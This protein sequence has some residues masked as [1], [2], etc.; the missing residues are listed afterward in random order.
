MTDQRIDRRRIWSAQLGGTAAALSAVAFAPMFGRSATAALGD[1]AF[2]L[3][4]LV[5]VL[6]VTATALALG[7][8][9]RMVGV[10]RLGTG[11]AVLV[12]YV[13]LAVA[14]GPHV[15]GGPKRLL[16]TAFPIEPAGPE[17]AT[18]VAL[19]AL[20]GIFAAEAALRTPWPLAPLA[21]PL[22]VTIVG[23]VLSAGAGHQVWWLAPALALVAVALLVTG[24]RAHLAQGSELVSTPGRPRAMDAHHLL[25]APVMAGIAVAVGLAGLAG[26]DLVRLAGRDQPAD[27][28]ELVPQP[29]RP[30]QDVTPL[31]L[32]GALRTGRIRMDL[33]VTSEVP[34]RR[35]RYVTLDRFDGQ[36]WTSGA[37][38]IRAG[39]L[40]PEPRYD[41]PTE[42][43]EEHVEVV[44]PGPLGWLV[45]SGRPVRVSV[46][47]LGV[48]EATGDVV[49]PADR[50]VPDEFTVRSVVPR[51][52][53]EQL[54]AATP[55]AADNFG[56]PTLPPEIA[57]A[58]QA[59]QGHVGHRALYELERYFRS[60]PFVVDESNRPPT[61]HGLY[62][63]R[64]LLEDKTGTAEQ[65][66]SAFAVLAR[67]LGYHARV[68]VGFLPTRQ[69]DSMSTVSGRN[70]HAWVEVEF[71]RIG[72]VPYDPTPGRAGEPAADDAQGQPRPGE[73]QAPAD[74]PT[75][76]PGAH[77]DRPEPTDRTG[78]D[79]TE[80][81]LSWLGSAVAGLVLL[82]L[83]STAAV[84]V[85]KAF[86]RRR[87]SRL[88]DPDRKAAAAWRDTQERLAESGLRIRTSQTP[89]EVVAA[90]EAR[91]TPD[92][93]GALRGLALLHDEAAYAAD[94]IT[95][96]LAEAA[97]HQAGLARRWLA[98]R[99]SRIQRLR[100]A[101]D[102]RPLFGRTASNYQRETR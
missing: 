35:L 98:G 41:V 95:P 30:K 85:I 16:T 52:S 6:L 50:P 93:H 67:S 25:A 57:V 51:P 81:L 32:F 86:R 88:A 69:S 84:P 48:D 70:V 43:Y 54:A 79:R 71:T 76:A 18:V 12:V 37:R 3:S 7:V 23:V 40:L 47:D 14:P 91:F 68:V 100:A 90:A 65:Y 8:W 92:P 1:P 101:V 11:I 33:E 64:R 10:Y 46:P 78:G 83:L 44:A 24:M 59:V 73:S 22:T 62:Q 31:Q 45:S 63:I 102:P 9:T 80:A 77:P 89:W 87:R 27:V 29:V 66:A 75:A 58:A 97:W 20:G 56:D 61:G 17:L 38:Y 82:V 53:A 4:V 26:P 96:T 39:R 94:P 15:F 34:P 74:D 21:G 60:R 55:V 36:V 13:A 42:T 5:C 2:T 49:I 99:L 72:W 19:V 28:R